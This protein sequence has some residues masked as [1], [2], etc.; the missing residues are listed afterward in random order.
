MIDIFSASIFS[1]FNGF[2]STSA[3]CFTTRSNSKSL[4]QQPLSP[5]DNFKTQPSVINE[6]TCLNDKSKNGWSD[7]VQE[8][9]ENVDYLD[10]SPLSPKIS[11]CE[12]DLYTISQPVV[13]TQPVRENPTNYK[14]YEEIMTAHNFTR[15]AKPKKALFSAGK[16]K[17]RSITC[18]KNASEMQ[19]H[20]IDICPQ[21]W[22]RNCCTWQDLVEDAKPPLKENTNGT[23]L[24]RMSTKRPD[25]LTE[26][27][28][29]KKRMI[30]N[31]I[32]WRACFVSLC[33][34]TCYPCYLCRTV[35]R[36]RRQGDILRREELL[37]RHKTERLI[38]GTN[39][40]LNRTLF[41]QITE[42]KHRNKTASLEHQIKA[43]IDDSKSTPTQNNEDLNNAKELNKA[44]EQK[45]DY[46]DLDE[47]EVKSDKEAS[48]AKED[49]VMLRKT[50]LQKDNSGDKNSKR[51]KFMNVNVIV[52]ESNYSQIFH[53]NLSKKL[54]N[55]SSR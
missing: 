16:E 36:S 10:T 1:S 19:S 29:M 5:H 24:P 55:N 51:S 48:Q 46:K 33:L 11:H 45:I 52:L 12:L 40:C 8:T 30:A 20:Q 18:Y 50:S 25:S 3:C 31:R 22:F 21:I 13:T 35:R 47:N 17:K 42:V 28:K 7:H 49:E 23:G 41:T 27:P 2:F 37:K 39:N 15:N 54:D 26:D 44:L 38:E 53:D 32:C 9:N 6:K 43:N 14:N 4:D 34:P